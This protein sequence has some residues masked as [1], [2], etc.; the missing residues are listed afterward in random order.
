MRIPVTL[1]TALALASCAAAAQADPVQVTVAVG[2][3]VQARENDLGRSDL[4]EINSVLARE[5]RFAAARS[6]TPISRIDLVIQDIQP[7]RPTATQLGHSV[8]LSSQ[9]YSLGGAAITGT[10]VVRGEQKPIRFRYFQ[11]DPRNA[12]NFD[13][14][15]DANQAFDLLSY[16]IARGQAPY[17]DKPWPA[18]HKPQVLTGT[19]IGG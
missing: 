14:W 12:V 17:D 3:A 10:M 6:Q 9:S 4:A 5:V 15:G 1:F 11:T 13:M 7:N 18:P 19:R 16:R 8:G 2:P